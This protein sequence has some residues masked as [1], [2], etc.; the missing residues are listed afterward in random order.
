MRVSNYAPIINNE[1]VGIMIL[2]FFFFFFEAK[3]SSLLQYGVIFDL[4]TN[5]QVFGPFV[6][7]RAM[8]V[9]CLDHGLDGR[10]SSY[11]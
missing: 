1:S 9:A 11:K 4:C 6:A 2:S 5:A 8:S 10:V 7:S 3:N